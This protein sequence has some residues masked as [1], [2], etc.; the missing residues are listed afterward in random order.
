MAKIDTKLAV[1]AGEQTIEQLQQRYQE[2]NRK[3]IQAETQRD[4]ATLRL[5][6][7]KAQARDKYG[8][9]DVSS[10]QEQLAG[11]IKENA[12]KKAKY[13]AD[14]DNIEKGL[15]AVE[16]KFSEAGSPAGDGGQ[17]RR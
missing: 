13:Q 6:E 4:G 9:D 5:N 8:T 1:N 3:K 10:L 15:A 2:L 11:F 16:A 7:L 14:L 17:P 12:D